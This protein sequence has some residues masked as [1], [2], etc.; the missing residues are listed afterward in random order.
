MADK[1]TETLNFEPSGTDVVAVPSGKQAAGFLPGEKPPAQYLNWLFRTFSRLYNYVKDGQ[2]TGLI[3]ASGGFSASSN[4]HVTTSGTGAH[5]HGDHC[6]Q[7]NAI[8]GI[9]NNSPDNWEIVN[10][11]QYARGIGS[12]GAGYFSISPALLVGDRIKSVRFTAN[13]NGSADLNVTVHLQT[14]SVTETLIGSTTVTNPGATYTSRTITCTPTEL[15]TDT[16]IIIS[17]DANAAG[18]IIATIGIIYD[19]PATTVT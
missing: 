14:S 6:L 1:P 10:V 5:R 12:I 4:Q 3:T 19:R 8:G 16:S 13:G 11:A 18:I 15:T 9:T 17:F 2:F 7:F